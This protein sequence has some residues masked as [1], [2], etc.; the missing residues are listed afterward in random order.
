M[1]VFLILTFFCGSIAVL[2]QTNSQ[3]LVSTSGQHFQNATHQL[4]F[5][6]GEPVTATLSSGNVILTQGFHQSAL[7]GIGLAEQAWQ[8]LEIYP[9]PVM[10]EL[11]IHNSED[12]PLSIR[13]FDMCGRLLFE[14]KV[15]QNTTTS[16][17]M[18]IYPTGSYGLMVL[19]PFRSP[20]YVKLFKK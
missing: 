20:S 9:N 4:S 16:L 3:R 8:A 12:F 10:D 7:A 1:R 17:D 14:M 15:P 19:F 13:L 5:S 11:T 18:H 6:I 2:A